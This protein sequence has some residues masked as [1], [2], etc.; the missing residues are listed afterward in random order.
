MKIYFYDVESADGSGIISKAQRFDVSQLAIIA[1]NERFFAVNDAKFSTIEK[2]NDK[3]R[4]R[5]YPVLNESSIS[6][7]NSDKVWGN[8]I[9]Y[10]MFS[11]KPVTPASIKKKIECEI[12][13]RF[14]YFIGKVDLAFIMKGAKS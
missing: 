14:G 7:Y 10:M 11:D 8:R 3:D 1:E 5:I 13:K 4:C 2:E 6:I 12:D 9:H